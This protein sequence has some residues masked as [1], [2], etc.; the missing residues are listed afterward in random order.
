MDRTA[1]PQVTEHAT[2]RLDAALGFAQRAHD[3]QRRNQNAQ[4]FIEHPIAVEALLAERGF[5]EQILIAGYLHDTVEKTDTQ[6][7]EIER[8]FGAEVAQIVEAL[9]EDI[10]I[11]PYAERKRALR[12]K[13]LGGGRDATIVYA[14]DRLHTTLEERLQL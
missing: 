6:V 11:Q 5:G 8:S 9:S 12:T 4:P 14:A 2:G 3:G 13:A 10:A 1:T 7:A